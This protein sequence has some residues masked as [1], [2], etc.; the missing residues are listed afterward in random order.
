MMDMR[1]L[2]ESS[3]DDEEDDGA[4]H[5]NESDHADALQRTGFWGSAGA[6]LVFLSRRTGRL[7]LAHR[8]S[9]VEQPHTW[10]NWG[11]AVDRS[12]MKNPAAAA[13]R[14]AREETGYSGTIDIVPAFRF[15]SGSF[16]YFNFIGVVD[17]EFAPH[18][19]WETQGFE[20]CEWGH[21]PSPLHFGLQALFN[22]PA[23]ARTIKTLI[24]DFRSRPA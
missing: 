21:W 12:E 20:W 13:M 15:Q 3:I 19:N 7:L 1:D 18:R 2:F 9:E 8:S 23:S 6:G 11:G 14:E 22:D 10:G 17:N 24:S 4:Y 5:D 16:Q